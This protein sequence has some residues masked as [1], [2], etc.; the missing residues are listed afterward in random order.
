VRKLLSNKEGV[1]WT[2]LEQYLKS[3]G[4]ENIDLLLEADYS[5]TLLTKDVAIPSFYVNILNIWSKYVKGENP[6]TCII[7]YNRHIKIEQKMIYY[8]DFFRAGIKYVSDLVNDQGHPFSFI[9][10]VEKGIKQTKWLQWMSLIKAVKKS[11]LYK[12]HHNVTSVSQEVQFLVRDKPIDKCSAREIYDHLLSTDWEDDVTVPS[13]SKYINRDDSF[14]WDE[15]FTRIYKCTKSCKLQEFQ[16]KFLHNALVNNA[17]L[18]KCKLADTNLCTMCK[19]YDE[20]I[21][22]IIWCCA[23]VQDFWKE[24]QEFVQIHFSCK[25]TKESVYLGTK[26]MLLSLLLI[27]AKQFVYNSIRNNTVPSFIVYIS[28]VKYIEKIEETMFKSSNK[29]HIW[30]ERWHPFL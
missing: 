7:W 4:I 16:F 8:S 2:F 5:V 15:V 26:N 14:S 23:H 3:C 30:L 29:Y 12:N 9:K 21:D 24:L 19:L 11:R 22:H 13:I 25:I 1:C 6:R 10:L 27:V 20:S 18:Y 17:W 28:K